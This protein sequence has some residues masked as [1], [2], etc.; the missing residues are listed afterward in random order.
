MATEYDLI[1]RYEGVYSKEEQERIIEGINK[2]EEGGYLFDKQ[3]N[4]HLEDHK[5]INLTAGG[6]YC[7]DLP[8]AGPLAQ[9]ILRKLQPCVNHY[10]ERFS[11]LGKSKFLLYDCKLKKI[12]IG[13]GFHNW[14]FENPS[15]ETAQRQ[16]VVQVYLN[17]DFEGGETEFLYQNRREQ[18]VA[19]DV[20]IFPCS[21]THTH[22]GNPPIG[23]TKYIA[24]SWGWVQG[25]KY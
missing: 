1:T 2:L 21:Y 16:F 6:D 3:D 12:P 5:T 7:L 15:I 24:T 8:S 19:G 20:L 9:R 17:D 10:L 22:R 11:V 4:K 18:A 23:G 14:H 25:G 13:G